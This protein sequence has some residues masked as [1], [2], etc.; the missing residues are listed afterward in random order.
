MT[1]TTKSSRL[2]AVLASI[3]LVL[4]ISLGGYEI[5]ASVS[6]SRINQQLLQA[7]VA[8]LGSHSQTLKVETDLL[9]EIKQATSVK[10]SKKADE[11]IIV[12]IYQTDAAI[13]QVKHTVWVVCTKFKLGN[14][15]TP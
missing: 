4:G 11:A 2:L 15:G 6:Q 12:K 13:L 5:N 3:L 10:G 8:L 9:Q 1:A 14:C 7:E